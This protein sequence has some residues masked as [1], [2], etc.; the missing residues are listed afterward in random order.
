MSLDAGKDRSV[1]DVSN[2]TFA[3]VRRAKSLDRRVTESSMT[4]STCSVIAVHV[5]VTFGVCMMSD[6]CAPKLHVIWHTVISIVHH[7]V[8]CP[9]IFVP[10]YWS[11]LRTDQSVLLGWSAQSVVGLLA[12]LQLPANP[13]R[14]GSQTH[15]HA[16]T[17]A[18]AAAAD[19]YK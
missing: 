14:S 13:T 1:P 7:G 18:A 16:H 11:L 4:V 3:N 15:V 10:L 17:S 19:A 2:S 6:F 8:C 12:K 5:R 9:Q